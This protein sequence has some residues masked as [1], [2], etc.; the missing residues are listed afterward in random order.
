MTANRRAS[1]RCTPDIAEVF[2][3]YQASRYGYVTGRAPL[4]LSDAVRAAN[5]NATADRTRAQGRLALAYLLAV[6]VL[7]NSA[8]SR[9]STPGHGATLPP[10]WSSAE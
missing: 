5:T 4:V 2:D 8:T 10:C 3:A 1:T 7:W 6:A 9:S